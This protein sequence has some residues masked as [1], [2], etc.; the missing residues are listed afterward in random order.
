MKVE[1]FNEAGKSVINNKGELVCTQAFP[2]MPTYFWDDPTGEKY[3]SAY[4]ETFPGYWHHSDYLEI[5]DRGGVKIFGRSDTT[6][7]PG[8]VRI[9]TSE[10]YQ[11]VDRITEIYFERDLAIF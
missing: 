8:G 1:A 7:N 3:R 10:I 2:S 6:L 4:F 11:A 9:G 5:N